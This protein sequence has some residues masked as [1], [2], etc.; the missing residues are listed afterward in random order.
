MESI[1]HEK[2]E[3]LPSPSLVSLPPSP[4]PNNPK[5]R[6]EECMIGREVE[7]GGEGERRMKKNDR[8]E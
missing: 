6:K 4:F 5:K 1:R 3:K 7:G 8:I 2:H